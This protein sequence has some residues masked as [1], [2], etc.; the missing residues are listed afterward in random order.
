LYHLLY[1]NFKADLQSTA[2]NTTATLHHI[3]HIPTSIPRSRVLTC[4]HNHDLL[5]RLDPELA[6][7]EPLPSNPS[8]SDTPSTA[9]NAPAT[10]TSATKSYRV[11]DHMHT[12]PKGLWDTTVTFEAD[13]TDTEDGIEWIIRAPLG[14]VQRTTWRVVPRASLKED[15]RRGEDREGI[16]DGGKEGADGEGE[17]SLVEDVEIKANRVIVGTVRGKCESNWRGVHGRFLGHLKETK[18]GE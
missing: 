18:E 9:L 7:Y 10:S 16:L 3:T 1:P 8:A 17:W 6:H 15:E 12:L 2:L 13:I 14:L 4:L 11:T 5:I